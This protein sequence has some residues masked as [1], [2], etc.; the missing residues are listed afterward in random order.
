MIA[1][2]NGTP[3]DLTRVLEEDCT[4]ELIKFSDPE[5]RDTF[6]HSSAH[7]LGQVNE[8]H[9]FFVIVPFLVCCLA[10]HFNITSVFR[11]HIIFNVLMCKY[12]HDYDCTMLVFAHMHAAPCA[13]PQTN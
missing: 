8:N 5:G 11:L 6:W 4:V 13:M 2:V 9:V 10:C 3:W 1:K 12:V 7:I